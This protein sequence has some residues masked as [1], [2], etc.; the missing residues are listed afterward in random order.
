MKKTA[1]ALL[2]LMLVAS[3]HSTKTTTGQYS[4]PLKIEKEPTKVGKACHTYIPIISWLYSNK[5][6]TVE[7]ARK[8]GNITEI[9]AVEQEINSGIPYKTICTIVR[10]N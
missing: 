7:T 10:G 1:F 2:V 8:N 9:V 6:W 3:C 5:D 4:L